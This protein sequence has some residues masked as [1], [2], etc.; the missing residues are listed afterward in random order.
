[1]EKEDSVCGSVAEQDTEA[2]LLR[3]VL[4]NGILAIGTLGHNV[5]YLFPELWPEQDDG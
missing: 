2:L 3:D 1:M 4:L 5:N